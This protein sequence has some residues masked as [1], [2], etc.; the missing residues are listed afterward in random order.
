[1]AIEFR[2]PHCDRRMRVKLHLAGRR[3]KC[4][5]CAEAI[6]IPEEPSRAGE[7]D[8]QNDPRDDDG[9]GGSTL[10]PRSGSS[11]RRRSAAARSRQA[12]R[13]NSGNSVKWML[14]VLIGAPVGLMLLCCGGLML[15]G[16]QASEEQRQIEQSIVEGHE[17]PF[18]ERRAGFQTRIR[19]PGPAPQEYEVAHAPAGVE[20]II[21]NSGE[22]VLKAWVRRSEAEPERRPALVFFHGG[23]AF[24]GGDLE[25]CRPF[26][27]A[28]YVVMAPML[29][30][31]NGNPGNFELFLGEIDDAKAAVEWIAS[32]PDVDPN[33]IY[34]FGHSV[35]GGVSAVLSLMD[36]V[37]IQHG[38]SSGGL[39]PPSVFDEWWD[40]TPFDGDD[41]REWNLRIL[42]GNQ[43]D[44]QH[45][46]YA[47][48]G[49]QDD[50]FTESASLARREMSAGSQLEILQVPG[51]HFTSLEPALRMYLQVIESE[52]K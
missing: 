34:T 38:G 11:G 5:D 47:Y 42:I 32:Q 36:G 44:M 16:Y 48:L 14:I 13:R 7:E 29:R 46:H 25:V 20:E 22:L 4:P 51:D 35:G 30:G 3:V 31:E 17:T 50:A 40:T 45:K 43:R 33:R 24:G 39:Y 37:P 26:V 21:Y 2:C 1:M 41:P 9:L 18:L 15:I 12:A 27:D 6:R 52:M 19:N 28:G 23:F 49:M 8:W 10:P